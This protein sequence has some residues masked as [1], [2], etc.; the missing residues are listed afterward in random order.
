MGSHP[1]VMVIKLLGMNRLFGE[2]VECSVIQTSRC[3]LSNH[4]G[5]TVKNSGTF[6]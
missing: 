1:E 5:A 6:A 4:V 3:V 2:I